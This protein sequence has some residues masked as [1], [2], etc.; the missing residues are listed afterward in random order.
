MCN[1][2]LSSVSVDV[3]SLIANGS[4][5]ISDGNK[6][7]VPNKETAFL[8][9]NIPARQTC[10]FATKLCSK[11]CY[12]VKA[13]KAY[14]EVKPA[15]LDNLKMS[16]LPTFVTD[17]TAIILDRA[18]RTRKPRLI[19][20]IHE[21]G[22]FYSQEY[23]ARW[24]QIVKNVEAARPNGKEVIFIA[25]TKSFRFFDG[26][27]L[28]ESFRLRASVWAD[29][30]P[31]QLALIEKNGWPIYT[32]VEKFS[33]GDTFHQCRCEDCAGCGKC[34]SDEPLICCEIH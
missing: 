8:I 3:K 33:D 26:V 14:K 7:L 27:Q 31:D 22:D 20:R 21:S 15:R 28:P 11:A 24:I 29:T 17:M 1:T 18:R 6:K 12:A 9:W 25:Y 30:D 13:E 5:H 19:V 16:M 2:I 32:A 10:P 23:A 34:W 4:Y